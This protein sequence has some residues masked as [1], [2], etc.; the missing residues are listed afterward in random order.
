MKIIDTYFVILVN[1][2]ANTRMDTRVNEPAESTHS[3]EI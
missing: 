2:S 1:T 3:E